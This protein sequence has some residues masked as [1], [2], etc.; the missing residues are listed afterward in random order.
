MM[1]LLFTF[2]KTHF[3]TDVFRLPMQMSKTLLLGSLSL[4]LLP[5]SQLAHGQTRYVSTTGT[6]NDPASATSWAA[7]TTNLQGAIANLAS[8]GGGTVYV[9]SGLY[10]P[11][12]TTGPDSRTISF[13]LANSVTVLGG[14]AGVGSPGSRSSFP[15]STLSGEIGDPGS[16]TDNSYHVIYNTSGVTTSAVLDGFVITGGNADGSVYP[17]NA[18]GGLFNNGPGGVCSPTIRNCLFERNSATESGGAIINNALGGITNP[19]LT[20]C[21]FHN[22]SANNGGAIFN[23]GRFGNSS[24]LLTNCSFLNNSASINGGAIYNF[25]QGPSNASPVFTNCSFLN[26][27]ANIGGAIFSDTQ[28]GGISQMT[29]TNCI[30]FGNGGNKTFDLFPTPSSSLV[31]Q[32]SLFETSSLPEDGVDVSGPGNLTTTV[33]P[34]ASST[35]TQLATCSPAI[36]AGDNSATGLVGITTDLAGQPRFFGTQV[37]MGAYEVQ[38]GLSLT[39]IASPSQTTISNGNTVTLTATGAS[40]YIWT[41]GSTGSTFIASPTSTTT[42]SVT[43]TDGFCSAVSSV[44]I[45][46]N[47]IPCGAV[48]YVTES[49]SGLQDGS[50]WANSL[51][52]TGLQVAITQATSC[53]AQVWVGA[54]LYK[55]TPTTDRTISFSL[56]NNVVIY[57][58]FRGDETSVSNRTLTM[59]S[60]STL[61]G[62]IGDPGS[63]TDNSYHVIYNTSGL[64]TSAVLDGF[65][66]TGGNANGSN[67]HS[68]GGGLFNNGSGGV[69]SPTIRNCLFERNSATGSGGAIYNGGGGGNSSPVLTNCSFQNNSANDGGAIYNGGGASGNSSPILTNCSFQN[70]SANNGGAINNGGGASGN[71][72][73]TLINCSFLNNS[74]LINGGAIRNFAQSS[75]NAS[76]VFTNCSFLNNSANNSGGAISS[77]SQAGGSS[78]MAMTNCVAYGNA[79]IRAFHLFPTSSSSLLVQYSLFEPSS[80]TE[81]G[82]DVSGPGNLTTTVS[83]FASTTSTQLATCSPAINAGDNSATGLVGI[84]TDLAGQPR[85]FGTQVDMGA[86]ELQNQGTPASFSVL[87]SGTI[88]CGS[89]PTI[90]LSGSQ[91]GITYQLRRNGVN[92]GTA[93]AGTGSALTFIAQPLVGTYTVMATGSVNSCTLVMASSATVVYGSIGSFSVTSM[94]GCVGSPLTLTASGCSSGTVVWPGGSTGTTFSTSVASPY[95]ATCTI[96][97]CTT[98][99]S[100]TAT[101]NALPMASLSVNLSGTLTCAQPSLTLTASGGTSY[102]FAG[103]GLVSQNASAGTA[104]VNA[105]GLY[106]VTVTNTA[107]GCSSQTSVQVFSNTAVVSAS[108]VASGAIS[109][110]STSVTLTAS[111]TSLTYNFGA[112][113]TQIGTTNQATVA[114]AGTYSVIVTNANGCSATAHVTVTGSTTTPTGAT[115]TPSPSSTLTCARTSLTLSASATG[116]GLSYIFSGPTITAQ[117]GTSATINTPGTYTVLITGANSCT[118]LATTTIFSNTL[119]PTASLSPS[120]ATLTCSITS[121]TLTASGGTSYSFAGTG[122]VSQN[123]SAGTAVVNA[124]GVY[125][126]T[127][128]NTATGCSSQTTTTIS[129]NTSAP[130]VSI[131]PGSGTLT[132]AQPSLTLTASGTPGLTYRWTDGSTA[133][134]L[135]VN[136][137]N[138]YSVTATAPNGCSVVSN[139]VVIGQDLSIPAF[140]VSSV[141]VCATQ[142][143]TLQASGCSGG[144]VIWSNGTTGATFVAIAVSSSVL[145]ASCTIGSC[146]TTASGSVVVGAV[147]PPPAAILSLTVHE[148]ACPVRLVG[149]AT[150]TSF[151]FTGTNGYV[152]SNVYR[153]GG[154]YDVFGEGVLK[155]GIYRLTVSNSNACGLSQSVSQTVQVNRSC[156]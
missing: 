90:T 112:A 56:R 106:S 48:I 137:A 5:G 2:F 58:G 129:S 65:V 125:S 44:T 97:S 76:P 39:V 109:C 132:C 57:G 66:I 110:S 145:T 82:V 108:L 83:P 11:T 138:T 94:S 29:M 87:G 63:T 123:T 149:R 72:S 104:V 59:P 127:V 140:T 114:A 32:Y 154:T 10:T 35:S 91:T 15:S 52:G 17:Y 119:A 24:P 47:P 84:T 27:S 41:G 45:T 147:L 34:F 99:A 33:S 101:F 107:T 155:A 93:I 73:P 79:G 38:V 49:G 74:A 88:S 130:S 21:S 89:S 60:S 126:V 25:A 152:Y 85:L 111:P 19:V 95:T 75:G 133:A 81:A 22:N 135:S 61:S 55:P 28:A 148:S 116:S 144:V 121:V 1:A 62:E 42:Y 30:V 153:N 80:A 3:S 92:S 146:R 26:N 122:L 51:P 118:T 31:V 105:S 16:T 18:G 131:S 70:N 136:T 43:G 20:N 6:N 96:G 124:S 37:D 69:C 77:D 86:Y 36:D 67:P 50:S 78:Q 71:S 143:A 9:A 4:L 156:P 151:V 40:S 134:T 12:T 142:Q 8:S 53:S 150:G 141:S 14:Y 98:T 115:L 120:S 23:D 113:A 7:S 117:S 46:V 128:T 64:T 103:T 102:S 13:S 54:G 68:I 100:G 139:A